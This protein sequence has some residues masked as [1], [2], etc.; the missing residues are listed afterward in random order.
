M[1]NSR[2]KLSGCSIEDGLEVNEI[3]SPGSE[4]YLLTVHYNER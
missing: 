4:A 3:V 1:L 2:A